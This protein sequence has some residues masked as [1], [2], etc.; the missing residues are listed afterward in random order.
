MGLGELTCIDGEAGN[1]QV[2]VLNYKPSHPNI[3]S[4]GNNIWVMS[5]HLTIE[6]TIK[7]CKQSE[8]QVRSFWKHSLANKIEKSF[9]QKTIKLFVLIYE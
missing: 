9:F 2:S 3:W 8:F 6:D 5:Q 4:L 1:I 7:I